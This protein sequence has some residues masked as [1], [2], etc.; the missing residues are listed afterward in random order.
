MTQ[1][2]LLAGTLWGQ[3]GLENL[4]RSCSRG[5]PEQIIERILDEVSSFAD[6]Q[7][8]RDDITLVVMTVQEGCDP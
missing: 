7:K 3:Q 6:G 5:T 4:L 1:T 8:Q 2:E